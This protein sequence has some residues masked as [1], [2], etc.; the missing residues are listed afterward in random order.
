MLREVVSTEKA[1][2]AIGP[3][4]QAIKFN[5]LLFTSG[6]IALDPATGTL[7]EGDVSAQT[8]QVLENLKAVL[9]AGG[10]SL[11]HV[12]KATVYLTDLG[13]F[14]KMNEVYAEY[15]GGVK[16]ARSTVGVA[17]LPRGAIVEIDLV[18]TTM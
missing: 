2:K 5:G 10:S 11:D 9:E 18:A 16:P 8:R 7:T 1:P 6:Q 4:E 3:Y 15:L 13:N 14:A 17:T 12:I